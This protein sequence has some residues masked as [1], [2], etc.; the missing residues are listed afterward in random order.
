MSGAIL[1]VPVQAAGVIYVTPSGAGTGSSWQDAMNLT[2]ALAAATDGDVLWVAAGTYTPGTTRTDTFQLKP[3]V[4]IYG[5]FAGTESD[6][7]QRDWVTHRV[8]LSGEIGLPNNPADNS[9]HVVTGANGATLDGI[10]I[11]DGNANVEESPHFRGGGMYNVLS[12][13]TLINVIFEHNTATEGGGMY[14]EQSSPTLINVIF[15]ENSAPSGGG[16]YNTTS[17]PSLTRVSFL[18]NQAFTDD[19]EA[20]GA[21]M[22]NEFSDPLLTDVAFVGNHSGHFGGGMYN[23]QSDPQITHAVFQ[24]NQAL[25]G[26]GMHNSAIS[27]PVMDRVRFHANSATYGGAMA[28]LG[29]NPILVSVEM[30]QNLATQGGA[31]HNSYS[32]SPL[33]RNVTISGNSA[34]QG[35]GL[36]NDTSTPEVVNSIIWGNSAP[37]GPTIINTGVTVTTLRHSLIE[38]SG[39]SAAWEATFGVDGGANLD[40]DPRFVTTTNLR[41]QADSPALDAGENGTDLWDLDDQ[42]RLVGVA[43]DLGAYE[44][45]VSGVRFVNHA[46]IGRGT[47]YSWDD[48]LPSLSEALTF[49]GAGDEVWVATGTYTPGSN[50][51]DTFQLKPGVA[52][53]G[54]FAATETARDARDWTQYPVVLSGE[55]GAPGLADNSYHIVTGADA[56]LLDGFMITAGNADGPDPHDRGAAIFNLDSSPTLHN[57]IIRDNQALAGGAGIA[58]AQS[59]P[60]LINLLITTNTAPQGAAIWNLQSQPTLNNLTI[61]DHSV[62][63][64]ND[65]SNPQIRNTIIWGNSSSIENTNGALPSISTSLVQ[66]SGGSAAWNVAFGTDA[67][68]NLDSDPRFVSATNLTLQP[69]SPAINAGENSDLLSLDLAGQSRVVGGTVDLGVY[70]VQAPSLLAIRRAGP[71]SLSNAATVDYELVFNMPVAGLLPS[72]LALTTS[73]GQNAAAIQT[74][75]QD[76]GAIWTVRVATVDDQIGTIRLDL[77]N[78]TG[79]VTSDA[80]ERVLLT[81]SFT[82]GAVYQIDREDPT[83]S[84]TA[85][86]VNPTN[87]TSASFSFAGADG[88]GSGVQRFI[89]QLD[90]GSVAECTSP[91]SLSALSH[92]EHTFRVWA[93]DAAGNADASP[94]TYTWVVDTEPP[95]LAIGAPSISLTRGGPVSFLVSYSGADGITLSAADVLLETTGTA[96]GVV[97]VSGTGTSERTVTLR[98]IS[99]D[100][101]LA[102]SLKSGTAYDL[103]SNQAGGAGP[104]SSFVV[105]NTGATASMSSTIHDPTNEGAIPVTLTFS[106]AVTELEA[107]DLLLLNATLSNF[108]G[109]GTSYSFTLNPVANGLVTVTVPAEVAI[110]AAGNPNQ[111][112]PVFSRVYDNNPLAMSFT[113]SI[114]AT[115]NTNPIPVRIAF[116][117]PVTTF[118]AD[119]LTLTNATLNDF[120]G[121][122]ASYTFNLTPQADGEVKVEIAAGAVEDAAGNPIG[123]HSLSWMYDSH[124]PEVRVLSQIPLPVDDSAWYVFTIEVLDSLEIDQQSLGDGD[125]VLVGPHGTLSATILETISPNPDGSLRLTFKLAAPGGRWD[126]ADNGTYT[127]RMPA[128]AIRD[129]AGNLNLVT[130]LGQF[131]LALK[132]KVFLPM[133]QR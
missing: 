23:F 26:G 44:R 47:G 43:V 49:A 62:A 15:R 32:S 124:N 113:S 30:Q 126:A 8:I 40:A 122:G 88:A 83:T 92:A 77:T 109:S 116:G 21:G 60:T 17:H 69:A 46:A 25:Y 39:G 115:T 45:Q 66:G 68:D 34:Q 73:T 78:S 114:P 65:A 99:G 6:I 84:I 4:T 35:G 28:N 51:T 80:P 59:N 24:A 110:D 72:H 119:D 132:W 100:G 93:H 82:S 105:D 56:A 12:S 33:L 37:T 107:A 7:S 27:A 18:Q 11:R 50:R 81:S 94:A 74:P 123:G 2:S 79:I 14:N 42:P 52:L 90:D 53:Y 75:L 89:C 128:G 86:P 129:T 106:E 87:Q 13:P 125:V 111:V 131:E 97:E 57:L 64:F 95:T 38:G 20:A 48:A 133:L 120:A 3:N 112:S 31:I 19:G 36:Y 63:I 118:E 22:Y 127:L 41:L 108:A 16:M 70:E 71:T 117:K 1:N 101:T 104:S 91:H 9:Y 10:T 98:N 103:A 121:S 67:G 29:G 85:Q 61:T 76:G 54:G 130:D 102:M 58:N 5:G 55:I 96:S